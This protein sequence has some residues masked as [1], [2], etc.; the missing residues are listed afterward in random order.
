MKAKSLR[1]WLS[2]LDERGL[3]KKTDR[4]IDREFEAT[5]VIKKLDGE[6]AVMM[7]NIK[8]AKMPL[9]SGLL[10]TREL[11]AE[12]IDATPKTFLNKMLEA[13]AAPRPVRL[14]PNMEA[15]VKEVTVKGND[16]NLNHMFP[17]PV[18]HKLDGG[19]YITAG[20]LIA[21]DPES[22]WVNMSV[23]RLQV[24]SDRRLG[25]LILPRHLWYIFQQAEAQGRDLQIAIAIGVDPVVMLTSQTI[26]SFGANELE[27]ASAL[28]PEPLEVTKCETSDL[29]VPAH[30]E[31]LLEG[32]ILAGVR[33]PEGPFG[34]FP[35]YYG[36][37]KPQPVIE[38]DVVSHRKDP[39]YH[40]ILPATRE[41]FLLGAVPRE[42][43][44]EDRI[45]QSVPTVKGVNLT[46]GG[47]CRYHAVVS[48]KKRN[49][50][51]AKNAIFAA[52]ASHADVKHV[53]VVDEDIDPFDMEA[54]EWAIATR[55][56]AD[57]DLIVVG[58][59]LGSKLDPSTDEGISAKMG[60]DATAPLS[61]PEGRF[62]PI[63]IPGL[64]KINFEDYF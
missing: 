34:E 57:K 55:F 2:Y 9:V 12:A 8:G 52:F 3:V 26:A 20:M 54:V 28:L 19:P 44:L 56:Q 49:E 7:S 58:G 10:F 46:F 32:R 29:E 43:V 47:T 50:G 35:K 39:I 14:L 64:D 48:I 16:I 24:H 61:A 60:L 23:H 51:E 5:A 45:R 36:P 33:E 25:A 41:H 22:G 38:I 37:R 4:L 40:T 11:I 63:S 6:A 59:A 53:V 31:I 27:V 21:R 30:C 18:H 17:I 13:Q 62:E 1:N 42:A 15:P